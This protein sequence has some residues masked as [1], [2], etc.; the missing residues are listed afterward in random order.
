VFQVRLQNKATSTV[1]IDIHKGAI[2]DCL[3]IKVLISIVTKVTTFVPTKSILY[4][5]NHI[6]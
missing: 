5:V 1:P 3:K 4:M 6:K 2:F